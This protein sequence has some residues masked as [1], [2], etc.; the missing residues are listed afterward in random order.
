[1][2]KHDALYGENGFKLRVVREAEPDGIRVVGY[3]IADSQGNVVANFCPDERDAA[4]DAM[5]CRTHNGQ[6]Q[7]VKRG[8]ACAVWSVVVNRVPRFFV[9]IG[10]DVQACGSLDEA[11][12]RYDQAIAKQWAEQNEGQ[13]EGGKPK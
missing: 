10:D 13:D 6:H 7:L 11:L 9:R 2:E 12:G 3:E 5:L 4:W 8:G 1:M